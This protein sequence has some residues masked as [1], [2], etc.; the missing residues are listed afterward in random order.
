MRKSTIISVFIIAV[1][2]VVSSD[3]ANAQCAMCPA[4]AEHSE[5]SEGLNLG[6]I[7]LMVV[8]YI[9]FGV[10]FRKRIVKFYREFRDIY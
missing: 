1:L 5:E 3:W 9:I 2:M 7:Y 4:V 10:V 6:I 8:P